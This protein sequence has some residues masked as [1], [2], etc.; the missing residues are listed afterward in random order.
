MENKTNFNCRLCDNETE[1]F[2]KKKILKKFYVNYFICSN[3][4]SLQTE[5]PYWLKEAY[6]SSNLCDEL[7]D[8]I[9]F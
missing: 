8:R 6:S 4:N 2:F 7:F 3:C 1:Y 9:T 5:K